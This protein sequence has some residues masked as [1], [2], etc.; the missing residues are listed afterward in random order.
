MTGTHFLALWR[1]ETT[2]LFSR[3]TAK[4]GLAVAALIGIGGPLLLWMTA[5]MGITMNGQDIAAS[6]TQDGAAGVD[7]G[8]WLR[9]NLLLVRVFVMILGALAVAGEF[10]ARTLREDLLRPVP[11]WAVPLAKWAALITW[12]A[13]ALVVGWVFSGLLSVIVFGFEGDWSRVAL[14][15]AVTLLADA[16][17]TTLV[18]LIA[19]ASRSVSGTVIGVV[20]YVILDTVAWWGLRALAFVGGLLEL[21]QVL[22]RVVELRPWFPSS[23]FGV[24]NGY[25]EATPWQW[26]SFVAL[27]VITV[28]CIAVTEWL[29]HRIDVP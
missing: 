8:L 27:G 20:L 15:Y 29:F 21:P 2:K 6:L 5:G 19:V 3:L 25:A 16:G 26:Q 17:F 23:A 10:R 18:L 12:I 4:A 9:N 7:W 28:T 14:G 22:Q 11:R 13:A 24:W 1:A